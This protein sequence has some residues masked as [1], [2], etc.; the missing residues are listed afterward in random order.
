MRRVTAL[1]A[2]IV[3]LASLAGC[4]GGGGGAGAAVSEEEAKQAFVISFGSVL[5]VSMATAF[6]EELDGVELNEEGDELSL[7]G[8]DLGAYL[9]EGAPE[10]PYS[11]ISGTIVNE[12]ERMNAD[13]TLEGGPVESIEFS[14]GAEEM[15]AAEGFSTTL[16]VNGRE[17]DLDI[18]AEDLQG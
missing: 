2:G 18:T 17:M 15:Q 9:G 8:F 6:G 3:L 11:A 16:T 4:G 5:I 7:D 14:M 10:T 13:L 1:A 12:E